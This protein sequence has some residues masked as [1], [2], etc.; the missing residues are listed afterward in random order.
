MYDKGNRRV[1]RRPTNASKQQVDEENK[2][3]IGGFRTGC[4]GPEGEI[5]E[6]KTQKESRCF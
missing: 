5:R 1:G 3:H 2:F 6:V 4:Q